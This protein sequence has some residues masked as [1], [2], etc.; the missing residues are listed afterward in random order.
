MNKLSKEQLRLVIAEM[1]P[2]I[3]DSDFEAMWEEMQTACTTHFSEVANEVI[4]FNTTTDSQ[5]IIR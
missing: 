5:G 2:D 3:S 4:D 1:R